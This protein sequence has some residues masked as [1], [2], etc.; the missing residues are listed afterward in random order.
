MNQTVVEQYCSHGFNCSL[1]TVWE[2]A[3]KSLY[4]IRAGHIK[5]A[6]TPMLLWLLAAWSRQL[7]ALEMLDQ[8]SFAMCW[9]PCRAALQ[10]TKLNE[11]W[12]HICTPAATA[13]ERNGCTATTIGNTT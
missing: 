1:K 8:D 12:P 10:A 7:V 5:V 13:T 3:L 9:G 6:W 4:E 2:S 11:A